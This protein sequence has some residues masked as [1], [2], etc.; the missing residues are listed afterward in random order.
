MGEAAAGAGVRGAACP[1]PSMAGKI[2][3]ALTHVPAVLPGR[4]DRVPKL[5]LRLLPIA[6]SEV[7]GPAL[8]E[9]LARAGW[10]LPHF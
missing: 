10:H 7:G 3:M 1:N 6:F 9:Q 2:I 8:E 5:F 4:Q